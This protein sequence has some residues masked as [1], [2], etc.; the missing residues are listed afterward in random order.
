VLFR[1]RCVYS[2]PGY[3]LLGFWLERVFDAPLAS[4]FQ[5][6]IAANVPEADLRFLRAD[7]RGVGDSN[8]RITASGPQAVPVRGG[9]PTTHAVYAA[10]EYCPVRRRV[11]HGVVH[12]EHAQILGGSA[13]HAGLFGSARSVLALL[14]ALR[15]DDRLL[16]ADLRERMW[17][18]RGTVDGGSFTAGWDTPSGLHSIDGRVTRGATVGH[19]GFT[20]TSVWFDRRRDLRVV[21]LTNRVH[22]SRDDLRIRTLRP[23]VHDA[24]LD[25]LDA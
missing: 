16:P 20:G 10:T 11:L 22:P 12:D 24:I 21:L 19:L 13:G 5:E 1:S 6:R 17:D 4:L 15:A 25:A 23:A 9:A 18:P 8:P 7:P 2:D 14:D 3:L